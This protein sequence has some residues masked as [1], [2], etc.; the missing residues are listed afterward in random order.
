M[1][2]DFYKDFFGDIR[3]QQKELFDQLSMT[4]MDVGGALIPH[5]CYFIYFKG[6]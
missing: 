2:A 4:T 3:G 1:Q 5:I 6:S